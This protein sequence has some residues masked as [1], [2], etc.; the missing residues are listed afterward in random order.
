MRAAQQQHFHA[1]PQ[2]HFEV[3]QIH[4]PAVFRLAQAIFIEPAAGVFHAPF[5]R[6]VHRRLNGDK[7]T[8]IGE[9]VNRK[10]KAVHHTGAGQRLFGRDR[11]AVA[12]LHPIADGLR[13]GG[14]VVRI[15]EHAVPGARDERVGHFRGRRKIH[16]GDPQRR[17]VGAAKDRLPPIPL[18]AARILPVHALIEQRE[19]FFFRHKNQPPA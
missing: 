1:A 5:E 15:A 7:I 8:R 17:R 13:N 11:K 19:I 12:G 6:A 16:I 2:A 4:L 9:R 3:L 18:A 10:R 14:I